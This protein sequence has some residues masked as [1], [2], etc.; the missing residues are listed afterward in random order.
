MPPAFLYYSDKFVNGAVAQKDFVDRV[1]EVE[2]SVLFLVCDM[3]LL[4]L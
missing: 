3:K 1:A 4:K 2:S